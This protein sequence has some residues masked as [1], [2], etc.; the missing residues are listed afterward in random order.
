MEKGGREEE[1]GSIAEDTISVFT[2]ELAEV[3]LVR[4]FQGVMSSLTPP[5]RHFFFHAFAF[6]PLLPLIAVKRHF[7]NPPEWF[8]DWCEFPHQVQEEL[9]RQTD[10]F[11]AFKVN[12]CTSQHLYFNFIISNR[13]PSLNS[14][15]CYN[16]KPE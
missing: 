6:F 11:I 16:R 8:L 10:F 1:C 5:Y 9:G 12:I 3:R 7:N 2:C 13:L 14:S 4:F 15:N